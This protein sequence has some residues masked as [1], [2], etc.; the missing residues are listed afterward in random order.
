MFISYTH[1]AVGIAFI[2]LVWLVLG[3][4]LVRWSIYKRARRNAFKTQ[5]ISHYTLPRD[6][7]VGNVCR[8]VDIVKSERS[9]ERK[10]E[11]QSKRGLVVAYIRAGDNL[12]LPSK[13][14][15]EIERTTVDRYKMKIIKYA[16][17]AV[18]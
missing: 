16:F 5:H 8:V 14:I 11:L 6:V 17:R 1:L 15:P 12:V 4:I 13:F 3:G 7:E 9:G 2:S 18:D 10:Y